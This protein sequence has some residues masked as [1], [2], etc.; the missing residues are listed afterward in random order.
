MLMFGK[1]VNAPIL[2]V[3]PTPL[4]PAELTGRLC[5]YRRLGQI[6]DPLAPEGLHVQ[7]GYAPGLLRKGIPQPISLAS[8]SLLSASRMATGLQRII[9]CVLSPA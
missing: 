3:M 7:D 4:F 8:D 5:D 9:R 2:R 1:F 6:H